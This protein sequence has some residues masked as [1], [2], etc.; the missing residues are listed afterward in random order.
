M[1]IKPPC[2]IDAE[3][4]LLGA[5][6]IDRDALLKLEGVIGP[7]SFYDPAHQIIFS[8]I[9]ELSQK[10]APVDVVTLPE[11]L[12]NRN[13]LEKVGGMEK[14]MQL[15][16][17]T[18]TTANTEYY[19]RIIIDRALQR[20]LI[21]TA[22]DI[23]SLEFASTI[24]AEEL[25]DQAEQLMMD[26]SESNKPLNFHHIRELLPDTFERLEASYKDKK[27]VTGIR[28]GFYDLD[29]L[30]SGFQSS[31]L[32]ILAARPSV[33]KTS[34]ALNIAVNAAT[35]E[36]IPIAIFS[37]EM[38]KEQVVE[39]ILCSYAEVDM[40]KL[41]SGDVDEK[42]MEHISNAISVFYETPI[43]ID[44]TP[45][46][47]ILDV[48]SKARRLR[49]EKGKFLLVVDYLQLMHSQERVENRV[50]EISKIT[51]QM[52]NLARELNIPIL[53]LSQLSREIEKRQDKRPLLSDLRESGSIEQD[54]D[55]VMFLHRIDDH[56]HSK[57]ELHLAKQRNGP[58]G[59]VELL[60]ERNFTK[61]RNVEKRFSF[62]NTE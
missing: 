24:P 47:S 55:V 35:N 3:E 28:T 18:S 50:Q 29:E 41:R 42:S 14:I 51:R 36:K 57:T 5:I 25:M 58:T 21:R 15:A 40:K 54:A 17:G 1:S 6:L 2:S 60:F 4:A 43:Y 13:L 46:V 12:R 52:K 22:H 62:G 11:E 19:A 31:D 37:L 48:R 9:M 49:A 16:S 20:K 26:L 61:F 8:V 59:K 30:T 33:G 38:S 7:D 10:S 34:F 45:D 53:L 56:D 44:D 23:L 27:T 39:R 32:L